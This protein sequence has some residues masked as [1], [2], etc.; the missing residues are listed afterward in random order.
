[1]EIVEILQLA[2][3]LGLVLAVGFLL[4]YVRATRRPRKTHNKDDETQTE[5]RRLPRGR[6]P[7]T[8]QWAKHPVGG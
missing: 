5:A 1:M 3:L 8:R 4:L 6:K 2:F 7:P